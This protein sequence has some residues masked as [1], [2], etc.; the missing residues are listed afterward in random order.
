MQIILKTDV[1]SLGDAGD[2]VD[3]K[4]GYG[5]NY[6]IPQGMAITATS[7][8]KNQI[9]HQRRAISAQI[10]RDHKDAEGLSERLSQASVTLTRLVGDD[11]K[12]FGSVSTKDI[13]EAL[14]DQGYDIDRRKIVLENPLKALGVYD[15]PVK[16][17]RD[18]I[19]VIKV[20]VVAD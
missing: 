18:V 20:W 1:P 3:V 11:D 19:A 16:I 15:V 17:H 12:L 2:L 8:N 5:S 7:A 13:A 4:P 9:E 10:S 14:A 6:L